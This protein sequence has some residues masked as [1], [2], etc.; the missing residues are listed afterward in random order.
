MEEHV[1]PFDRDWESVAEA[2]N[3]NAELLWRYTEPEYS[4][5]IFRRKMFPGLIVNP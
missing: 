1:P 2:V 4:E 5:L 3:R